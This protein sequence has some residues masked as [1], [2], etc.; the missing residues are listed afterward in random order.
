MSY[1]ED[2]QGGTM[3][4]RF[5]LISLTLILSSWLSASADPVYADS[6]PGSSQEPDGRDVTRALQTAIGTMWEFFGAIG[7]TM[8]Q[9]GRAFPNCLGILICIFL[10]LALLGAWTLINLNQIV[11][12]MTL[13]ENIRFVRSL[14]RD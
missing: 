8:T 11:V 2:W 1:L 5:L 14:F 12:M 9:L 10:P 7:D 13:R 4:I 6:P 3:Q